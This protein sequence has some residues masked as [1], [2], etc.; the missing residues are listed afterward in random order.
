MNMLE[1]MARAMACDWYL[2]DF[3]PEEAKRFSDLEYE[4]FMGPAK[5]ALRAIREPDDA[6]M[7]AG[8]TAVTTHSAQI[9]FTAMIDAILYEPPESA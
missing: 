7:E 2:S 4:D 9:T 6:M 5:A 3:E 8:M 1:K